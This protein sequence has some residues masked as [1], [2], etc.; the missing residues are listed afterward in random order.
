MAWFKSRPDYEELDRDIKTDS[1]VYSEEQMA[2]AQKESY[3]KG[4]RSI[5]SEATEIDKRLEKMEQIVDKL[6]NLLG[7]PKDFESENEEHELD[8]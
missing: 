1:A 4:F 2:A 6:M 8:T 7:D 5:P 3:D